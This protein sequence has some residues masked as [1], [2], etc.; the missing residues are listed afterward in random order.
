[1]N[2]IIAGTSRCGKTMLTNKIIKELKGFSKISIDNIIGS[3]EHAL[4]QVDINFKNG[5]G[6]NKF[7]P[8]FIDDFLIGAMDKDNDM[9]LYYILEGDGL[10]FSKLLKL[11]KN[12]NIKLIILGKA[13][14]CLKD[15]FDETRYYEGKYLYSEW[16]KYLSDSELK[17]NCENWINRSKE[18]QRL[19]N[20]N[21]VDF[22][23]TSYKQQEVVNKIFEKIK[24]F[25]ENKNDFNNN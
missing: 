8:E 10:P 15:Y 17:V 14:I 25:E 11:N 2:Y 12:K 23:D 22:Y 1:M 21:D 16:T 19:C 9:G 3:F 13:S 20:E 4:P 6:N 5:K 7:L 24:D 18:Y